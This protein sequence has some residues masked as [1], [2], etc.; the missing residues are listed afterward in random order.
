MFCVL[1]LKYIYVFNIF[2]YVLI[3]F[4]KFLEQILKLWQRIKMTTK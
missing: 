3:F 4:F 1:F 2:K